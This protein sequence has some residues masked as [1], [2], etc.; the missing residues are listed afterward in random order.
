MKKIYIAGKVTGLPIEEVSE[1]SKLP[2]TNWSLKALQPLIP[3][4]WLTILKLY[5]T[6]P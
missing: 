3:Y 6:K 5:G 2:K 4:W 1:N